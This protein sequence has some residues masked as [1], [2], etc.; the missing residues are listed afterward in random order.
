MRLCEMAPLPIYQ[1]SAAIVESIAMKCIHN[2][3]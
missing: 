3:I 2:V 1:Y